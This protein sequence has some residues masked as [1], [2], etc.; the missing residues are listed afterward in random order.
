MRELIGRRRIV[1]PPTPPEENIQTNIVKEIL[2]P[3]RVAAGRV[4]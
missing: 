3:T 2:T 4:G 1:K